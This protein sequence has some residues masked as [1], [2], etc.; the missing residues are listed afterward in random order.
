MASIAV[1]KQGRATR[2]RIVRAAAE[3][4]AEQGAAGTSLDDVRAATGASKSQLYHYF[5]DKHGLVEAVVD[6]QCATVL[7]LQA[8]A[9]GSVNDWQDLERWAELMATIV[10]DN[11]ARGGCPIGTLAAALSDTDEGL[12]TSLSEAF[13]AWSDAIRGAL[14]RLRENGLI[15]PDA[16]LGALT[17]ITLSAIQGGLL[18]AKTSRDADQLRTVLAGAIAQLKAHDTAPRA[19][20]R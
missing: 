15:S 2:E 6:F 10:E 9:L 11:G 17:T 13:T 20:R 3:L 19:Q 7:G 14:A 12:R 18:L 4:V 1:T 5:G 16:D 8:R